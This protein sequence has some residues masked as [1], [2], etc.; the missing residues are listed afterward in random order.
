[1]ALLELRKIAKSF[2]HD[3]KRTTSDAALRD[4]SF[5]LEKGSV[6]ALLGPSGCGKTTLLRIIAGLETP[7]AGEVMFEGREI[8][9]LAPHKRQFGLMFQEFAL[10]PHKNVMENVAFGL[11]FQ[12]KDTAISSS[13]QDRAREVLELV[14]LGAFSERDVNALSGGEKQ[15]VALARSLAP[16]P[17]LLMLD[18]PLG[19]LDR[20]LRE[21]LTVELQHILKS[22]QL[23]TILVTHDQAEAFAIADRIII[24]NDGKIEQVDT[25]ERIYR[26]PR[27]ATV[28]KFLGFRNLIEGKVDDKGQ[29]VTALGTIRKRHDLLAGEETT[30]LFRPECSAYPPSNS[31]GEGSRQLRVGG[32]VVARIFQGDKYRVSLKTSDGVELTFDISGKTASPRL[33]E[34]IE[35]TIHDSAIELIEG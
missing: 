7:D 1:M 19:S 6:V 8:R 18:E 28:A 17:K 22:L 12:K 14:G 24:M 21:E 11:Q 32:R 9:D 10:F 15:R 16:N 2:A 27:N 33:R 29:I 4:I 26:R 30:V 35:L 31:A 13:N 23:T 34:E 20:A 25:P 5:T 3:S